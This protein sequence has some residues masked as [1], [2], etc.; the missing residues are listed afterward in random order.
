MQ[1]VQVGKKTALRMVTGLVG[2]LNI[3]H[4][5]KKITPVFIIL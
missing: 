1:R 5:E 4:L 3:C 2:A